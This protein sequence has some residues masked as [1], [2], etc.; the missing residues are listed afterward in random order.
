[1]SYVPSRAN[2][3]LVNIQAD[4]VATFNALLREGVIVRVVGIP[5]HIRVS[6][7]TEQENA[8]FLK[9]LAKVLGK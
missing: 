7:G 9:A 3:L 1:M 5:Q 6:I 8:I 2:F 4:A